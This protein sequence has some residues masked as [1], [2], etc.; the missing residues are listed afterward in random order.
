MKAP[1]APPRRL[2]RTDPVRNISTV[3]AE[4]QAANPE[5]SAV[6]SEAVCRL[7]ATT[8]Q[9]TARRRMSIENERTR[10]M[11]G[12]VSWESVGPGLRRRLRSTPN[13]VAASRNIGL[14]KR[15]ALG[16]YVFGPSARLREKSATG[17]A[18]YAPLAHLG[19]D[20]RTRSPKDNS[21][22]KSLSTLA[23]QI[24][25]ALDRSTRA[26]RRDDAARPSHRA[27]AV[28]SMPVPE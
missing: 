17:V 5:R 28:R 10:S 26:I 3:A 25:T 18:S 16:R 15:V 9:R 7:H 2:Q 13:S 27:R 1:S 4:A 8:N 19:P 20:A 11:R 21:S 12:M 14:Q 24:R 6:V 22:R 23:A